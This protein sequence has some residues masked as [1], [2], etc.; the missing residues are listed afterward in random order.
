MILEEKWRTKTLTVD[1]LKEWVKNYSQGCGI[2][3]T[4]EEID[5]VAQYMMDIYYWHT[6][7]IP[8]GSFV[9]A[10]IRNDLREA[11]WSANDINAKALVLYG[12]LLIEIPGAF[13]K[14]WQ[15]KLKEIER[16]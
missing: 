9:E 7:G 13:S 15:T 12:K 4:P 5:H 2:N 14:E 10:V 16:R 8:P 6:R 11:S 1:D 3:L